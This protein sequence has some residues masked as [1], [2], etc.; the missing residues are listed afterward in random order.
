MTIVRYAALTMSAA[1]LFA[2]SI[3]RAGTWQEDFSVNGGYPPGWVIYNYDPTLEGWTQEG[4]V[5]KGWIGFTGYYSWLFL[6]PEETNSLEWANYEVKV[7][8]RWMERLDEFTEHEDDAPQFGI[9]VYDAQESRGN[10]RYWLGIKVEGGEAEISRPLAEDGDVQ[11]VERLAVSKPFQAERGEWIQLRATAASTETSE[12]VTFQVNGM[13][14]ITLESD[15][16]YRAGSIALYVRGVSAEFDDFSATGGG[17]PDHA[18]GAATSVSPAGK[19]AA[20][21]GSLKRSD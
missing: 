5:L 10:P 6:H 13:P 9:T 21:W 17:I 12:T 2:A 18:P 16:P 8:A 7:R 4:G 15:D 14:L 20:A 1:L 3:A 11:N 19:A